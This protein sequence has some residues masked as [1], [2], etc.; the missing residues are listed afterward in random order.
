MHQLLDLCKPPETIAR[1]IT[2][3]SNDRSVVVVK[4]R[5]I[6][7]LVYTKNDTLHHPHIAIALTLTRSHAQHVR[8]SNPTHLATG[9]R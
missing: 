7:V 2:E 5:D 8:H 9:S 3:G 4:A 1:D 6:C